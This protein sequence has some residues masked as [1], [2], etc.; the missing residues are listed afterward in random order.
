[1]QYTWWL[2]WS[3][4]RRATLHLWLTKSHSPPHSRLMRPLSV[5]PVRRIEH[6]IS[7]WMHIGFWGGWPLWIL[8]RYS[9]GKLIY[10]ISAAYT[11]MPACR[12]WLSWHPL[13]NAYLLLGAY[14]LTTYT[15]ERMCLLTRVYGSIGLCLFCTRWLECDQYRWVQNEVAQLPWKHPMLWKFTFLSTQ[16]EGS[17]NNFTWTPLDVMRQK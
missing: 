15:Y 3:Q 8:H 12:G 13:F 4:R 6:C 9:P 5:Y 2:Y 10:C 1:M 14:L 16:P 17:L 7:P 11:V